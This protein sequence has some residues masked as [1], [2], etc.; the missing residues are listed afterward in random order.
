[1]YKVIGIQSCTWYQNIRNTLTSEYHKIY[2]NMSQGA[3]LCDIQAL[4]KS[5]YNINLI[6]N[7][8]GGKFSW[9]AEFQSEEDYL[10]FKLK[11]G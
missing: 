7:I 2:F 6:Y 9:D 10:Y 3:R 1:M 4:W 8:K 5:R 11:W